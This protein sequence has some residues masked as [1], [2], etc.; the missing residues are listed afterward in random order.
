M[1]DDSEFA[2]PVGS[3]RVPVEPP[4]TDPD[5]IPLEQICINS[6]WL[7]MLRGAA[8]QLLL[9]ATW[10]IEPPDPDILALTQAR[11]FNLL[12][13]LQDGSCQRYFCDW[14]FEGSVSQHTTLYDAY[15]FEGFIG[16]KPTAYVTDLE[17]TGQ[18]TDFVLNYSEWL[19][20]HFDSGDACNGHISNI[21]VVGNTVFTTH[22]EV[23]Y[24]DH[25]GNFIYGEGVDGYVY[26]LTDNMPD[27][28][29][30]GQVQVT[31]NTSFVVICATGTGKGT[32]AV[33]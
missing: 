26:D 11:V 12:G 28:I 33:G 27:G 7:Q 2:V 16:I 23:N 18:R 10:K 8:L 17:F 5:Q 4:D 3:F 30:A 29:L 24:Y 19:Y 31:L 9:E 13:L 32:T 14:H 25:H 1:Y 6:D 22:I 20:V 15:D 21:H